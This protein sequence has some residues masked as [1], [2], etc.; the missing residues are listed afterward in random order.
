MIIY[1]FLLANAGIAGFLALLIRAV[2]SPPPEPSFP[3]LRGLPEGGKVPYGEW[4]LAKLYLRKREILAAI[5][6]LRGHEQSFAYR[7]QLIRDL[8][9]VCWAIAQREH[10]LDRASLPNTLFP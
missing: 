5:A 4:S 3:V 2:Q 6:S 10:A 9:P 7:Q 1:L 8:Q